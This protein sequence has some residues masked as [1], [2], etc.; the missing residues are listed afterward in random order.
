VPLALVVVSGY[1][2]MGEPVWH[3]ALP[4]IR[5]NV[6]FASFPERPSKPLW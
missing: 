6:M 2:F 1:L 3:V 5:F 4:V